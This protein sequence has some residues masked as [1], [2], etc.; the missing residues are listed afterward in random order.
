MNRLKNPLDRPVFI[1]A[2]PR[3]GSTLLYETLT[4]HPQ[5]VSMRSESH[6]IIEHIPELS[7]VK[8]GF[9]SNALGADDATPTVRQTLT[10]RFLDHASDCKGNPVTANA[11][12]RFLEKTPKNALRVTFLHALYPDAKFIYLIREP[13]ANTA[14][15]IDAWHSGRFVTYPD[16]PGWDGSW[17]LLL[18]PDWQTMRN[19]PLSDVAA[20]Q[21]AQTNRLATDAFKG[22]DSSQVLPVFHDDFLRSPQAVIDRILAFA[23]LSPQ[24]SLIGSAELPLSRYTLLAPSKTKW[25]RHA[26]AIQRSRALLDTALPSINAYLASHH[27]QSVDLHHEL[28]EVAQNHAQAASDTSVITAPASRNAPCPCGSGRRYKQCHGK[29]S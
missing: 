15:I 14:S 2:A 8:R 3:S 21:W 5:L 11:P 4:R 7:T 1:I 24:P 23:E 17:S 9:A 16:L 18:P 12:V 26:A 6:A 25:Y 19:R 27:H 13:V 28:D 22:I 20:F 10:A 29:L